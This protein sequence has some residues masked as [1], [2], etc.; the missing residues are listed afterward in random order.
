MFIFF[1][2]HILFFLF[3][4]E[5]EIK[6]FFIFYKLDVDTRKKSNLIQE[7]EKEIFDIRNL[8]ERLEEEISNKESQNERIK[9]DIVVLNKKLQK[10]R[11]AEID[12]QTELINSENLIQ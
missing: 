8:I 9:T 12:L 3:V 6:Y 5:S 10:E 7:T 4:R 11:G 2:L 1:G